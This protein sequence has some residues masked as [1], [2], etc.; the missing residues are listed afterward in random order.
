MHGC[1]RRLLYHYDV[2]SPPKKKPPTEESDSSTGKGRAP[3]GRYTAELKA[4]Y[5]CFQRWAGFSLSGNA[6]VDC[7][8][9][10]K[11]ST[12]WVL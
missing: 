11:A 8:V 5:W 12:Q 1:S 2:D 9:K 7:T 3:Q 6:D 10:N 4:E